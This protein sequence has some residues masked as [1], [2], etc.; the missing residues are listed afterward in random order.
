[1]LIKIFMCVICALQLEIFQIL[2]LILEEEII[3]VGINLMVYILCTIIHII[4][5]MLLV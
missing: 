4:V 2:V 1:M 3:L 5:Y